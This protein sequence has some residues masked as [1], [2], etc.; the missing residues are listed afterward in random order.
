MHID[1][2]KEGRKYNVLVDERPY[3]VITVKREQCE[4]NIP[5]RNVVYPAKT[6]DDAKQ[7][8]AIVARSAHHSTHE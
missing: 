1:F 3:A 8:A 5:L 7:L 4:V 2:V 6:L